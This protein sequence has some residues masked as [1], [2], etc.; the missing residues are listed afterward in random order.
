MRALLPARSMPSP[1]AA[2]GTGW[3]E[4]RDSREHAG[5]VGA[6]MVAT[7]RSGG[8]CRAR[9]FVE[10][11]GHHQPGSTWRASWLRRKHAK[12]GACGVRP[13]ARGSAR[14][15]AEQ[16]LSF[17]ADAV[18]VR[19]VGDAEMDDDVGDGRRRRE[20]VDRRPAGRVA[21]VGTRF[22]ELPRIAAA[23]P[24]KARTV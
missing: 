22:K 2:H 21:Q 5:H 15:S 20:G 14:G 8:G 24:V 6:G 18:E 10:G 1:E 16:G 19:A 11:V 4:R 13:R 12:C 7:P 3:G 9:R 17:G 23:L